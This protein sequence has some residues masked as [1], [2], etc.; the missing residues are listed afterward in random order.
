MEQW[1]HH[2]I[3]EYLHKKASHS[4]F[5]VMEVNTVVKLTYTLCTY[6]FIIN[7]MPFWWWRDCFVCSHFQ[8][9]TQHTLLLFYFYCEDDDNDALVN[10]VVTWVRIEECPP[11][12]FNSWHIHKQSSAMAMTS[13]MGDTRRFFGSGGGGANLNANGAYD[14]L[15]K[16]RLLWFTLIHIFLH[17]AYLILSYP[18]LSLSSSLLHDQI[19]MYSMK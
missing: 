7:V 1:Y 10:Y 11:T 14:M 8:K 18:P 9:F 12:S 5:L 15:R 17:K 16:M 2:V 6:I 19:K 3:K 4:I 13:W